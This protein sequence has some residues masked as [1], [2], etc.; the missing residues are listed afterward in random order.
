ME[1]NGK[2]NKVKFINWH[3]MFNL[4]AFANDNKMILVLIL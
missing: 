3:E 2:A 1:T 4:I